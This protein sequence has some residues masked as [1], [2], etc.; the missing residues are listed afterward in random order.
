MVST[1]VADALSTHGATA[2]DATVEVRYEVVRLLSEQLY[3]SP[4]KAIEELVVNSWDADAS[5]CQVHVP[6]PSGIAAGTVIVLDDGSGMTLDEMKDLWHVGQ[7]RK[8]DA[9][10][11]TRYSRA[12]IGKFG[13]GKLATYALGR[14]VTYISHRDGAT[15]G[16][17]LNFEQFE[18]ASE[19][20]GTSTPIDLSV[21]GLASVEE[22]LSDASVQAVFDGTG[23][24]L[25]AA[26]TWSSWTLVVV[27]D[28]TDKAAEIRDGRLRWVLSTAMPM[29]PNFTV[30]LNG[31]EIESAKE[32][33]ATWAA[34]FE[35]GELDDD[36]LDSLSKTTGDGWN[37][38]GGGLA[39]TLF[40]AGVTGTIR[41][42]DQSLYYG[43]SSDL[44]RSHGF[45]IRARNRLINEDD[46]LFGS[47]PLSFTTF[48]NLHAVIDADDLDHYLKA[49]RNDVEEGAARASLLE[50]LRQLFNQARDRYEAYLDDQAEVEK[51]KKEGTRTYAAPRLI[52][53]PLADS[54]AQGGDG[55]GRLDWM[56]VN[57][58]MDA[59][60][61]DGLIAALYSDPIAPRPYR[62]RVTPLGV[63]EPLVLFS[64]G[65]S[66][67]VLNEDHDLV[68]EY[69]DNYHSRRVLQ[70]LATAEAL[71]EVYL[72]DYGVAPGDIALLL[73]RRDQLLRS[74]ARSNLHSL[75]SLAKA[76][77]DARA[78]ER[79]L[80]IAAV[81]GCRALGFVTTQIS[82]AGE[83]DGI[84]YYAS[85]TRGPAFTIE[86]K[87]SATAPTLG[88]IDFAGLRAHA[89]AYKAEGC[90]LVAPGYP[91]ATRDELSQASRRAK[92]SRVSCWTVDQLAQV[93][94]LA[95]A[96]RINADD[97]LA[98]VSG[99]FTP[100][101]VR[102][103][104]DSLL[105]TPDWIHSELRRAVLDALDS[106]QGRLKGTPRNPSM[107]AT[108]VSRDERFAGIEATDVAAVLEDLAH[109]SSGM[110][111]VTDGGDI[112]VRGS[113]DELR[114]RLAGRVEGDVPD[115]RMG[116]FRA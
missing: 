2:A 77:R 38:S 96:R 1:R 57:P 98:V 36:R 115:R 23:V 86:A 15:H 10:W 7:S 35:V 87:S 71:L 43:K 19:P 90:L 65:E 12:Q 92:I 52:E 20:D 84:A 97:V 69:W 34:S 11:A 74:L 37:R 82:G 4:L 72:R 6:D 49:P 75:R 3:S 64:P 29:A 114:R 27:E 104:I 68:H 9:A 100:G 61:A 28:L 99:S 33:R 58:G 13:I 56:L 101:A 5:Q 88:S 31:E 45:F 21:L 50:L 79:D 54:L 94:E 62:Y 66:E 32:L 44:G 81:A 116:G 109:A 95:E 63:T 24:D 17:T 59:A 30:T 103:A 48:Y 91:G 111:Y 25:A 105:R 112:H 83:P 113:M 39:S 40:P 26:R 110:L 22:L 78:D 73:T 67:F 51:R 80:E 18:V 8:R 107:L 76:I 106:M 108:E 42:A 47:S 70:L 46:P 85:T 14:Q 53:R 89:D 55:S 60:A 102:A 93:V 16:V 41:V